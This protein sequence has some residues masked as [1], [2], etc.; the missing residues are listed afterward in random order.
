MIGKISRKEK[1][2]Y[3][4]GG[5]A[6]SA[7]QMMVVS[8]LTYFYTDVFRISA[9]AVGTLM[10]VSR[11]WDGINDPVMGIILDRTKSR[12]GRFRPYMLFVPPFLGL[13]FIFLFTIPD[14]GQGGKTLYAY[15]TYMIFI[16]LYTMYDIATNS[17]APALSNN[18]DEK[19]SLI[20]VFRLVAGFGAITAVLAI[21]AIDLLGKGNEAAGYRT[22]AILIAVVCVTA[23]WLSFFNTKEKV[24]IDNVE[25]FSIRNYLQL[26][27]G[28]K[29]FIAL[30][31][32]VV[33]SGTAANLQ[34]GLNIHYMLHYIGKP[35]LIPIL[36]LLA[37]ITYVISVAAAVPVS[38]K[39]SPRRLLF[40]TALISII[41]LLIKYFFAAD[42]IPVLFGIS[43]IGGLLSGV[44]VVFIF[45]MANDI[46]DYIEHKHF[47]RTE[48][49]T[50]SLLIFAQK[51][52]MALGGALAGFMLAFIKYNPDV[53]VLPLKVTASINA[54]ITLVPIFI[55]LLA[56]AVLLL[57]KLTDAK[58]LRI[59]KELNE[60][61][62]CVG[63][64]EKP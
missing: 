35:G 4:I 13:S 33:L 31:A 38:K 12:W 24:K 44:T 60:R 55:N 51:L 1:I 23:S 19:K 62:I 61:R 52:A 20:A 6:A 57:Y 53:E 21:P 42:N 47:R 3:G 14:F 28:N 15:I 50:F 22:Y 8:F 26:I 17:M 16:T 58:L 59:S 43:I 7:Y 25:K 48:G 39:I 37:F 40:L 54:V 11:L 46:I 49:F 9:A 18:R 2:S 30:L 5:I 32:F 10:L 29:P 56:I 45:M 63:T 64:E 41:L 34:A 27:K 36:T